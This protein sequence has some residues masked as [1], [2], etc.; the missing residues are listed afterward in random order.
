[1]EGVHCM[2]MVPYLWSG[3]AGGFNWDLGSTRSVQA[4]YKSKH[5]NVCA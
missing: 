4:G 1:M 5:V 3:K 2:D